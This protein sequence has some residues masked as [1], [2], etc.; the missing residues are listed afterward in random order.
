MAKRPRIDLRFKHI[1]FLTIGSRG[2]IAP[3]VTLALDVKK[4]GGHAWVCTHEEYREFVERQGVEFRSAGGSSRALLDLIG[5]HRVIGPALFKEAK[6]MFTHMLEDITESSWRA[7]NGA[8]LIIASP[9]SFVGPHIAEALKIPLVHGGVVVW[10]ST[11]EFPH[12]FTQRSYTHTMGPLLSSMSYTILEAGIWYGISDKINSWRQTRLNLPPCSQPNNRTIPALYSLSDKIIAFP[13]DWPKNHHLCGN[14]IHRIETESEIPAKIVTFVANAPSPIVYIG[15]GSVVSGNVKEIIE[16]FID[17]LSK[18]NLTVFVATG[19]SKAVIED[20]PRRM[21][22]REIAHSWLFP[23]VACVVHHC[24]VGTT[25]FT[26]VCGKPSI[27]VPFSG[28]QFYYAKRV[29]DLGIG[30][31]METP[32]AQD[33]IDAVKNKSLVDKAQKIGYAL[34]EERAVKR[35]FDLLDEVVPEEELQNSLDVK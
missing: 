32:V 14:L 21:V 7:C 29:L 27:C 9:Y 3:F 31:I 26:A 24:G 20:A 8:D 11:S 5:R 33:I 19:E 13:K 30:V 12:P 34:R 18:T 17:E 4:R 10:T 2:D 22:V 23:K 6:G 35:F 28:D 1:A 15:F 25:N 16:S